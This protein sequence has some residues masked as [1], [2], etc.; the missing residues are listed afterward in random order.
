MMDRDTGTEGDG[1]KAGQSLAARALIA[2][3]IWVAVALVAGGIILSVLFRETVE[4][5][6]DA[7]LSMLLDTLIGAATVEEDGI[8]SLYR[9][10][11]DPRFDRPYSG[12]YW[13]ISSDGA[14]PFRSRSLWD[15][16]LETRDK[17]G[18]AS[19]DAAPRIFESAGPDDQ[20]LR[21]IE[22]DIRLPG[23]DTAYH[24]A[25]AGDVSELKSQIG[26]F[27]NA[28]V[29]WLCAL[30][31]VLLLTMA[32]QVHFG[33][34]PLRRIRAALSDIR[35]GRARR[36]KGRFPREIEPLARELNALLDHNEA[37]VERARRHVGNLAHA[38]KTPL[39][40][41]GNEAR[42]NRDGPAGDLARL[43]EEQATIMGRHVDHHLIRARAAARGRVIG[44]RTPVK[45][46]IDSLVR[47][48]GR[49]YADRN[50]EYEVAV[51]EADPAFRGERQDLDDMLGNLLDNAGKWAHAHVRISVGGDK[52]SIIIRV[53]DDGPG[54]A[55]DV[56]EKVFHRGTRLDES[57]PGSGLGLAIVRDLAELCGGEASLAASP[58]GGLRAELRLPR[59]ADI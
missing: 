19:T 24:F 46:V 27:N 16:E 34:R 31:A 29:W 6:F 25:I 45:P 4:R 12:W 42:N 15:Q 33:L 58:M 38:L 10:M 7:R 39:S 44:V 30:G 1:L 22:R 23:S 40:V 3:A 5:N 18:T 55:E 8:V 51:N 56:R 26:E 50:L 47:V 17:P 53:E 13:Q 52:D 32:L 36:L 59:A 21:V 43:V 37:V 28:L 54:I 2:A 35:S 57:M 48:M 20:V 11:M 41:M 49:L 9:S 14:A